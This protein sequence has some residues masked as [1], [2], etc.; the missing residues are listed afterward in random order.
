MSYTLTDCHSDQ[1]YPHV[2][3]R[4]ELPEAAT[5][6]SNIDREVKSILKVVTDLCCSSAYQALD[7]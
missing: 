5:R 7:V 6:F 4:K 3:V 2:Q 1:L